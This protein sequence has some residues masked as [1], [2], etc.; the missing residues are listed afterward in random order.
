M[1]ISEKTLE[2][3]WENRIKN[4]RQWYIEHKEEF[5]KFV[6]QP[7]MELVEKLE[8]PLHEIDPLLIVVPKVGKSISRVHRDIRFSK[9]KTLYRDVMWCVFARDKKKFHSPVFFMEYSPRFFRYGCGYY[10]APPKQMEVLRNMILNQD[11]RFLEAKKAFEKQDTFV[12][13]GEYYKRNRFQDQSH[14][15]Q[16]WLNRKKVRFIK[17]SKNFQELYHEKLYEQ[18]IEGFRMLAPIYHLLIACGE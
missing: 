9:D 6:L 12:L 14:D 18:L 5:Q 15:L 10:H 8:K 2:F 16:Q 13:D 1:P 4:S 11:K 17:E 3:L 7:M